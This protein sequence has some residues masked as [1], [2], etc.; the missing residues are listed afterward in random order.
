[1]TELE[2]S[3]KR[4]KRELFD[5]LRRE[6]RDEK[7]LSAMARVPRELFVPAE[8]RAHAYK[9]T[10]LQ[11]GEGQ[12]I[13]QPFIVALMTSALDL[14]GREKVMELGTGSGYQAAVLSRLVPN[15]RVL[16]LERISSL[17]QTAGTL[18]RSLAHDNV[19]VRMAGNTLGCPEE[20]PYNAIIV[21][22]A[23]P[24]LPLV[25]LDQMAVGGRL[26][27]PIGTLKEQE[28]TRV[29]RTDEGHTVKMLGPCRF[30]PLVGRE[31]WPENYE[32]L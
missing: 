17:A 16:S 8:S 2:R 13:S 19:E 20:A 1:M 7:V 30:V 22:A 3:I 24:R 23:A 27:I 29:L 11:I 5:N 21:A 18:L 25:L 9:D 4:E 12:T 14:M 10:A 26:V 28:L 32:E 6:I 15:G 31:A